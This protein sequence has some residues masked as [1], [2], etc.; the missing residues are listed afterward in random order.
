MA[1]AGL[2]VVGAGLIGRRH[3]E[4]IAAHDR[5][6]AIVDPA[7]EAAALA[8]E[9]GVPWAP[10]LE[11][12]LATDRPAG[13]V[14]ATP[15]QLH[16]ENALSAIAAG[17]PVLI[18]K[19]I[20]DTAEAGARV[21]AA[22][23]AAGVPILVGHHRRHNPLIRAAKDA[24]SD[25]RLGQIVAVQGQFWLYKP[26]DYFAPDWRRQAGAGPIFINLIHDIDLLRH[27]CGEIIRVT[28]VESRGVRGFDVEDTAA[29]I[30]EFEGGALGTFSVSD[31]AVSP[32][33]WE[34]S[35]GENPAYPTCE[36]SAYSIA[37]THGALSIPDLSYWHHPGKRGWWEPMEREKLSAGSSNPLIEQIK[38]F[39]AVIGGTSEPLVS[40]K[41]GL[42]T[43]SVIEAIKRSA[44]LRE[45]VD[46]I[47]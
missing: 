7:P 21:V 28:A 8:S 47:Y 31:T 22:A 11:G 4:I 40:G 25:G 34:F 26:D 35:S 45:P 16:A 27:L 2:A 42:R 17:V 5:L 20:T 43:L 36:T 32:W 29:M 37:G 3:I 30:L 10:T 18:E 33:S 24:I 14:V 15:N 12:Y 46:V 9:Q 19:P 6:A 13:V 1:S 41:E 38:H 39:R 23:R 44:A